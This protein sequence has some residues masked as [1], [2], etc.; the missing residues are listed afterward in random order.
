MKRL[1]LYVHGKG[2]SAKEAD[3]Y[4]PLFP[5]WDVIGLEYGSETPWEAKDEFSSSFSGLKSGYGEMRLIANSIGAFFCLHSLGQEKIERAY[6]VSPIVDMESLIITMMEWANVE[7]KELEEKKTIAT[8]FGEE[9]S[10]EYLSWVRSNPIVW[11]VPTRIL[12]SKNDHL[13]S[14]GSMKA[15]SDKYGAILTAMEGG[16][17]YIHEKEDM[18]YMDQW[19]TKGW[20]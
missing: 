14:Y 11:N 9:L 1:L 17:H 20:D 3:H 7:E 5:D 6:F 2:G 10:W 8:S 15:F 19:M 18:E 16:E 12:Y 4:K 13:Q